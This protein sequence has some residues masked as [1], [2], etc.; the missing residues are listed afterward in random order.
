MLLRGSFLYEELAELADP[1]GSEPEND[2]MALMEQCRDRKGGRKQGG[3]AIQRDRDEEEEIAHA[4]P[5][6]SCETSRRDWLDA[7]CRMQGKPSVRGLAVGSD[8]RAGWK[9]GHSG[10]ERRSSGRMQR[11]MPA[12]TGIHIRK[13]GQNP[14]SHRPIPSQRGAS[15]L[16]AAAAVRQTRAPPMC[17]IHDSSACRTWKTPGAPPRDALSGPIRRCRDSSKARMATLSRGRAA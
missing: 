14:D 7:A 11:S 17:F 4:G 2:G 6:G 15:L 1:W 5:V 13:G 9:R 8:R 16:D 3:A 12:A 10:G